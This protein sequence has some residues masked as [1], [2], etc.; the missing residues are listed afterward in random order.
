MAC[1]SCGGGRQLTP[2]RPVNNQPVLPQQ[3]KQHVFVNRGAGGPG[4]KQQF[5]PNQPKTKRTQ[6]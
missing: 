3:S 2:N 6:V 5:A 1:A 4:G